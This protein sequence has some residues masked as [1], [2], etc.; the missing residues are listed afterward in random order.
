MEYCY[1]YPRPSVTVDIMLFLKLKQ[2]HK[3][4]LIQRKNPPFKNS[5]ALPGGFMD[6]DEL[7]KDAALRELKEE[8][9]IDLDHLHQFGIYDHPDRDP[10][11]R[12]ISVVFYK[13]LENQPDTLKA[14]DDAGK[15]Q[16]FNT[17]ELPKLAFDHKKILNDAMVL[18]N[19]E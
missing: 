4:L 10:R 19:N 12:T 16:W 3:I 9:N 2:S 5:W 15:A 13:F 11:G 14:G 17:N 6:I 8:T 7:L 18:F 1:K